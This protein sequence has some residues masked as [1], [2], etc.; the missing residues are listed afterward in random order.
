MIHRNREAGRGAC[1]GKNGD[2][3]EKGVAALE[4]FNVD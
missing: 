1:K 3:K 4:C 2:G